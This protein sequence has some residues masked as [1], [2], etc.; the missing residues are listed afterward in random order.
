MQDRGIEEGLQKP[1]VGGSIQ[2]FHHIHLGLTEEEWW[3]RW[4]QNWDCKLEERLRCWDKNNV[5]RIEQSK[6]LDHKYQLW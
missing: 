3:N 4:T 1:F 5:L 6:E 2:S